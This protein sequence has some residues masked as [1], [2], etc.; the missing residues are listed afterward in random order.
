MRPNRDIGPNVTKPASTR[1]KSSSGNGMPNGGMTTGAMIAGAVGLLA[2]P[3]AVLA[4]STR[5]EAAP[6]PVIASDQ[7]ETVTISAGAQRLAR[8][9]PMRA[10]TKDSLFPFTPAGT[11]NRPERSVTVAVRVD[12]VA[13]RAISVLGTRVAKPEE[14]SPAAMAIAPTGFSLGLSRGYQTFAQSLIAPT[15]IKPVDMPDLA[16]FRRRS[17]GGGDNPRFSGRIVLDEK[18]APGRAPRTF[19]GDVEDRVDVGGSY[20]L[21]R[22][23]DVTAGVRY[24]QERDRLQPL[25]DGKADN[26]AVYV[27]TQFRF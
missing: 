20:R 26:Q 14:A 16:S 22:N 9:L 24:S 18:Q 27:G 2:L 15:R 19:A 4:F 23:L 5:F 8:A 3:S 7:P 1:A 12:P 25:T 6:Q 17:G 10:L 13:G 21:T 11:A